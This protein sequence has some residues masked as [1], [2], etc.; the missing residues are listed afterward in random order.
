M[1]S[2][3][4][5]LEILKELSK[6]VYCSIEYDSHERGQ[7]FIDLKTMAKS[8]LFLYEDGLLRGRYEYKKQIDLNEDMDSLITTLCHEFER[9]LSG[10]DFGQLEWF[11]LCKKKNII[12]NVK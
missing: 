9:A 1:E 11:E 5:L 12:I 2:K 4:R 7:F 10:R 8:D 6:Y 3:M